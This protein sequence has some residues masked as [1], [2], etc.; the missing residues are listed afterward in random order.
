MKVADNFLT[1]KDGAQVVHSQCNGSAALSF[2]ASFP[3]NKPETTG[4]KKPDA[5]SIGLFTHNSKIYF[6]LGTGATA[7][8]QASFFHKLPLASALPSSTETV[9]LLVIDVCWVR[10]VQNNRSRGQPRHLPISSAEN[11]I[12]TEG[13]K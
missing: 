7:V 12:I 6:T 8:Q 4:N 13:P 2:L 1:D 11:Q 3:E 9:M 10:Y 5:W